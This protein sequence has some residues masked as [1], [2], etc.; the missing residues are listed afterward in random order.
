MLDTNNHT[1][2]E[3]HTVLHPM[4]IYTLSVIT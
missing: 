1:N 2:L 3:L 4:H